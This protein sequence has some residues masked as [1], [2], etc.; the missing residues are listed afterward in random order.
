[1]ILITQKIEEGIS[2]LEA[3]S[4]SQVVGRI[5]PV[6][7]DKILVE[8]SVGRRKKIVCGDMKKALNYL[9]RQAKIFSDDREKVKNAVQL[10]TILH[11]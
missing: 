8:C 4:G 10:S 5:W 6:F 3:A 1:M 11:N 2:Y 9:G 7:P